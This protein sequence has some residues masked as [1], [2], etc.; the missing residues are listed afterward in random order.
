MFLKRI[1]V[2]WCRLTEFLKKCNFFENKSFFWSLSSPLTRAQFFNFVKKKITSTKKWRQTS[3]KKSENLYYSFK[4]WQP[5]IHNQDNV[6]GIGNRND[7]NWGPSQAGRSCLFLSVFIRSSFSFFSFWNT[8]QVTWRFLFLVSNKAK[9]FREQW[10]NYRSVI[11]DLWRHKMN[12]S[13]EKRKQIEMF[14]RLIHKKKKKMKMVNFCK[15]RK[16]QTKLLNYYYFYKKKKLQKNETQKSTSPCS[17]R[18]TNDGFSF[19]IYNFHS[20]S[21]IWV[22]SLKFYQSLSVK[23]NSGF[24]KVLY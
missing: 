8:N 3:V 14:L 10:W 13:Q 2:I 21:G 20:F 18:S 23:A 22:K 11:G 24:I 6:F 19:W 16:N 1:F 15:R 5:T 7:F 12:G 9:S 17:T 4:I